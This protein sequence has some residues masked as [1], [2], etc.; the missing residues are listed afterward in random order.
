MTTTW[1]ID[2]Q[3][4]PAAQATVPAD[5][6]GVTVGDGVFETLK[7]VDGTP[8]AIGRHLARLRRSAAG[9]GIH[10]PH[11]DDQLRAALAQTVAASTLDRARLRVTVTAGRGPLASGR[12]E[13]PPTVLIGVEPLP[14]PHET[15]RVAIAPWAR[16]ERGAAAGIKTTSYA[17][18]VIALAWARQRNADEAILPNTAGRLCE[19]T[20]SN[21]FVVLDGKALTPPL[22]AGCLAG[23]TRALL[24]E[25][26]VAEEADLSLDALTSAREA[27]LTSTTRDIQAITAVDGRL[28]PVVNGCA[29]KSAADAFADLAARSNDP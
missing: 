2:G 25:A 29:T 8:F 17:E 1:W 6:H 21:V 5:D 20:G 19:G 4:A 9:L 10:V 24:L 14:P 12:G 22:S 16:N 13:T 28:L 11:D 27:F 23:I 26:G 18:N 3:L 7:V 15:S